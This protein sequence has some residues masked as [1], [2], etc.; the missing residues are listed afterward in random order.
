MVRTKGHTYEDAIKRLLEL[1]HLLPEDLEKNDAGFI[2]NRKSYFVEVKNETAPDYGA[3]KIIWNKPN[4]WH[5]NSKDKISDKFDKIKILEQINKFIPKKHS[6]LDIEITEEDKQSDR[7]QFEKSIPLLNNASYI[8]EYYA[9][10]RCYYIQIQGKGFYYLKQ[11]IANLGVP[12][13][14]P[15]VNFIRLRA[16]THG[17]I[18]LYNY[19]FRAVIQARR[20]SFETS[21]FDLEEIVGKFPPIN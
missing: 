13:F 2:H 15:T 12:Q 3:K 17:S 10:K 5:W 8:Y 6:T 18:P 19:S 7:R 16:K 4:R 20:N 11:D 21:E 14:T 1:R 9:L